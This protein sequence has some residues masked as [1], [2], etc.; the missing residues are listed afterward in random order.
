VFTLSIFRRFTEAKNALLH[1]IIIS[2]R[3][4]SPMHL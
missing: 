2:C 3:A 4:E 1:T